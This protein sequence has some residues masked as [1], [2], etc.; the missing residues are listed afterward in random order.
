MVNILAKPHLRPRLIQNSGDFY[1]LSNFGIRV[2]SERDLSFRTPLERK[3]FLP[4]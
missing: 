3:S 1:S 2:F 4:F